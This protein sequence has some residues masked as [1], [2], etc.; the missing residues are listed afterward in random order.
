MALN[1]AT[2]Q[3]H[4]GLSVMQNEAAAPEMGRG[5]FSH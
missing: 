3:A 2:R 5:R 1:H 4:N